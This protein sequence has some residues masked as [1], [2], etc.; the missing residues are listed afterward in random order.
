M[1]E[2][3]VISAREV[4]IF[5]YARYE[6]Q[7]ELIIKE[8]S[9]AVKLKTCNGRHTPHTQIITFHKKFFPSVN[10]YRAA[11]LRHKKQ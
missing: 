7:K 4:L 10:T 6:R 11:K 2:N 3:R 1:P 9:C 8:Y 5:K